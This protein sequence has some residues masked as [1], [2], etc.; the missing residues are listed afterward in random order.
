MSNWREVSDAAEDKMSSF[1]EFTLY[2]CISYTLIHGMRK[3]SMKPAN[4][5]RIHILGASSIETENPNEKY[6]CLF[7][8]LSKNV[9]HLEIVFVGPRVETK[10]INRHD[11]DLEHEGMKITL[12]YNLSMYHEYYKSNSWKIP[13]LL[14]YLCISLT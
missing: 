4:T 7:A 8:L 10:Y 14:L 9:S 3:L 13:D 5:F 1:E 2:H 11:H 12:S 6:A